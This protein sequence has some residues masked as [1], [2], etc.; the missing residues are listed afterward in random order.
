[1]ADKERVEPTVGDIQN[2]ETVANEPVVTE[3]TVKSMVAEAEA[4]ENS[5]QKPVEMDGSDSDREYQAKIDA[6]ANQAYAQIEQTGQEA[7]DL[8]EISKRTITPGEVTPYDSYG[9]PLDLDVASDMKL[10]QIALQNEEVAKKFFDKFVADVGKQNAATVTP[11]AMSNISLLLSEDN[12]KHIKDV[13]PEFFTPEYSA[14]LE[15]NGKSLLETAGFSQSVIDRLDPSFLRY[16]GATQQHEK[17]FP[18]EGPGLG[19][20]LKE[21]SAKSMILDALANKNVQRSLKWAGLVASC[22]TG[23]IVVKAGMSGAKFLVGKLAQNENVRA[24]ATKLENSSI[25]FVS[26]KF[27]IDEAKIRKNVDYAKGTAERLSRNKWVAL[28]TAAACVGVAIA[29]GQIDMVH[30]AAQKVASSAAD[31]GHAGLSA[32]GLGSTVEHATAA[33]D[34]A[35][36]ANSPTQFSAAR[37]GI[38]VGGPSVSFPVDGAS[39]NATIG[40]GGTSGVADVGAPDVAATGAQETHVPGLSDGPADAPNTP[41]V[42]AAPTGVD[43]AAGDAL[44]QKASHIHT[45]QPNDTV[46][47]IAQREL[48]ARGLPATRENIYKFVDQI[49]ENNKSVI[50]PD[51]NKIFPGQEISLAFEPKDLN[52]GHHAPVVEASAPN[53]EAPRSVLGVTKA[54]ML[55]ATQLDALSPLPQVEAPIFGH[56]PSIQIADKADAGAVKVVPNLSFAGSSSVSSEADVKQVMQDHFEAVKPSVTTEQVKVTNKWNNQPDGNSLG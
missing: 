30:D 8:L 1:M 28:G 36:S 16:M 52:L 12:I 29:L 48:Q 21:P 7:E 37:S 26:E 4:L 14:N 6:I 56:T 9:E 42:T 35:S 46:S 22:A 25:Q 51:V 34:A 49:Y 47:H 15:Q 50:G 44:A 18:V 11:L 39:P 40:S 43:H 5:G 27:K 20:R 53:V 2:T 23:G 54:E 17:A 38:D 32:V 10:A 41:A 33:V 13:A 31:L 45:V 3:P 19:D 55:K 24:F